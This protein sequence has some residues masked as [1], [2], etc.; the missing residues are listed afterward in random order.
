MAKLARDLAPNTAAL[1]RAHRLPLL[2]MT[3][4]GLAHMSESQHNAFRAAVRGLI[5]ADRKVDLFEWVTL[6]VLTRHL[7]EQFGGGRPKGVQ[8]F[9]LNKL[10]D[11]L[12]VLLSVM[13]HA[14]GDQPEQAEQSF[15]LGAAALPPLGLRLLEPAE[16]GLDRL[17]AALN[18][19]ATV[20]PKLKR[21]VLRACALCA[22][23]DGEINT[24]EAELLR[25][26]AD[27]LGVPV[28]PLLPGQK[29][30]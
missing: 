11:E 1:P 24:D 8:Y 9:A 6:G 16:S 2:D 22:G 29:L 3:L 10:G 27:T 7:D 28:P 5:S 23:A 20:T 13:V 26:I 19:L 30:V 15:R 12:G 25:A 14:G 18:R 4:G 21:D 17:D